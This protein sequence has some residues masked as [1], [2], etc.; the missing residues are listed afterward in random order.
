MNCVLGK[1][2][3]P[4]V[5]SSGGLRLTTRAGDCFGFCHEGDRD[6]RGWHANAAASRCN[7]GCQV[8]CT[9]RHT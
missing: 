8:G 3:H 7:A 1:T 2:A 9:A 6:G 5:G 4:Q